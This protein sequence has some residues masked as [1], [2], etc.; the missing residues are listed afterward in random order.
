MVTNV[1]R[2]RFKG[3]LG[4]NIGKNFDTPL[5]DAVNDYLACLRK[6]YPYAGYVVVNVSSPATSHL[7]DL[8][9]GN[10]LRS[11]LDAL[12]SEQRKLAHQYGNYV[13]LVIKV[14]PDIS[15]D[16]I[17]SM[18]HTLTQYEIDGVIATNSTTSR[19]GVG[20]L[21][22]ADEV[23]G[24]TGE[25]LRNQSTTVIKQLRMWLHESIPIIASGGIMEG[26]DAVEK[27]EAGASLV[28]IYTGLVY[29]GP[30]LIGEITNV[31]Q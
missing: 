11:L 9:H 5:K 14:S 12:K 31:L 25:P 19:E 6:V 29:Q 13:P 8:Q 28:Q 18:T 27:I 1:R 15:S 23:G 3:V 10:K 26:K 7:R 22:F 2:A 30:R 4:I 16:E 17:Q 24:L 21:K 20:N